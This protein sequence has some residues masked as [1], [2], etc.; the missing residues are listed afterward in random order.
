VDLRVQYTIDR[1]R[2]QLHRPLTVTE[3]AAGVGLSVSQLTRLF[4][5]DTSMTPGAFLHQLRMTTARILIER[6]SLTVLEVMMQV[7][8]SD[9]SHFARDFR[10]AHGMSPRALRVQL[11]MRP[12]SS[13]DV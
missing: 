4:R 2:E 12:A 13:V 8:I 1:M 10:R 7:G 11:R 5:L 3:L 9:P 6:T